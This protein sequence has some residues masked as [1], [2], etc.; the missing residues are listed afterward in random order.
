MT[1]AEATAGCAAHQLYVTFSR[2]RRRFFAAAD[3]R[4]LTPSQIAVL[5]RLGKAGP[6]SSVDLASAERVRPQAM[7]PI[8]AVLSERGLIE[9][10]GDDVDRR[11]KVLSLSAKGREVLDGGRG[12]GNEWLTQA[13]ARHCTLSDRRVIMR[14]MTVLDRALTADEAEPA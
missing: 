4:E 7:T 11:R 9:R 14:A 1:N 2:L 5:S 10:R 12:A 13:L 8:L 6:A 3:T